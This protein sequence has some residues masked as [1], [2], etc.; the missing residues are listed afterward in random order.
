MEL[1]KILFPLVLAC[2]GLHSSARM[3]LLTHPPLAA[4]LLHQHLQ[5]LMAMTTP[6]TF[7]TT[8]PHL[9]RIHL[10]STTPFVH[11]LHFT[12]L[13]CRLLA[14]ANLSNSVVELH[15]CS[16]NWTLLPV[17]IS[18]RWRLPSGARLDSKHCHGVE[19]WRQTSVFV[20]NLWVDQLFSYTTI[21]TFSCYIL[22]PFIVDVQY[23]HSITSLSS[24]SLFLISH[25][26]P[27]TS[28][29]H[30]NSVDKVDTDVLW[31]SFNRVSMTHLF[32]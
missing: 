1:M 25:S 5:H 28:V 20:R 7:L 10:L 21:S 27:V 11:P 12:I 3:M 31:R 23:I 14:S 26:F 6:L 4:S 18:P 17:T 15:K 30:F 8:H 32:H 2:L 19:S 22:N 9:I 29:L 16:M 13:P 24:I